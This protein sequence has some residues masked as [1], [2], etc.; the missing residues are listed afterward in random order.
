[1]QL[2]FI[3]T[4]APVF[5]RRSFE[6]GKTT[7]PIQHQRMQRQFLLRLP[8]AIRIF[9][10]QAPVVVCRFEER[11]PAVPAD[12]WSNLQYLLQL[13]LNRRDVIIAISVSVHIDATET[14]EG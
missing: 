7:F 1:M 3:R 2:A 6:S 5:V 10:T 12:Q 11:Q 13:R 4:P 8:L 9:L 14:G